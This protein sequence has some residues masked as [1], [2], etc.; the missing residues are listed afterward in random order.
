MKFHWKNIKG[1]GSYSVINRLGNERKLNRLL[2]ETFKEYI[3][4]NNRYY[5]AI[6]EWIFYYNERQN[7][8]AMLPALLSSCDEAFV[9]CPIKRK[10]KGVE[11][12]AAARIDFWALYDSKTVLLIET[13]QTFVSARSFKHNKSYHSSWK[14]MKDQL[15]SITKNEIINNLTTGKTNRVYKIGIQMGVVY[16]HRKLE[17]NC[18][19]SRVDLENLITIVSVDKKIDA[20]WIGIWH[21]PDKVEFV[22]SR[23]QYSQYPA[24][25]WTVKAER[26]DL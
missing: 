24:C 9:E 2:N 10:L 18:F 5:N 15:H 4:R 7:I 11:S 6:E 8:S 23:N 14:N 22:E 26:I 3:R 12:T 13:K 25:F 17:R 20:D 19:V 16:S 1:C 21:T